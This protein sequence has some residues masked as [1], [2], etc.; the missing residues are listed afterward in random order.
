MT[1]LYM[2]TTNPVPRGDTCSCLRV[3]YNDHVCLCV[4][5]I[6]LLC[7]CIGKAYIPL[8]VFLVALGQTTHLSLGTFQMFFSTKYVCPDEYLCCMLKS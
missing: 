6:M 4:I 2:C 7:V 3:L 5:I 8:I 1:A